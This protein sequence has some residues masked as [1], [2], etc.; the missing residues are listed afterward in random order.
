MRLPE[1]EKKVLSNSHS[2]PPLGHGTP[3]AVYQSVEKGVKGKGS[4]SALHNSGDESIRIATFR[5]LIRKPV[6]PS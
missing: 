5:Y 4:L 1:P 3:R 2:P 6:M